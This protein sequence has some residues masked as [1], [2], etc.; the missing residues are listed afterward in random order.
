MPNVESSSQICFVISPIGREGTDQHQMFSDVL[1]YIIRP[2]VKESGLTLEVIR[3]DDIHR[4]GSFIKDILDYIAKSQVV[5]ADLTGQNPNVFYELGVRHA[6]SARTILVAQTLEDIPSDL[7]EYRTIIYD[8]SA[9]GAAE[10]RERLG[11]FL[12]EIQKDPARADNPVLD[13]IGSVFETRAQELQREIAAL[14]GQLESVL[15]KGA[16]RVKAGSVDQTRAIAEPL[17]R[18]LGRILKLHSGERVFIPQ[19]FTIDT[20]DGPKRFSLPTDEGAFNLYYLQLAAERYAL[21]YVAQ[22]DGRPPVHL[23]LADIRVLLEH[24]ARVEGV[25]VEFVVAAPHA[26]QGE[27]DNLTRGFELL[28]AFIPE[29]QRQSKQ[30]YIWDE[31][32]LTAVEFELGI[33]VDLDKGAGSSATPARKKGAQGR[34]RPS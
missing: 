32:R 5:I 11:A 27:I 22:S 4:A 30:L 13:R 33:R 25:H 23:L 31:T 16:D 1:K 10:F 24:C 3:A 20:K 29:K 21:W 17:Q 34:Q 28:K 9:K 15:R 26:K 2:A 19:N 18:R 7:R 14:K 8:M 6:L 12:Q